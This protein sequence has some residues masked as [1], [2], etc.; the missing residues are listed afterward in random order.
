M[1][2]SGID[3]VVQEDPLA[4]FGGKWNGIAAVFMEG[5]GTRALETSKAEALH[6]RER[7]SI[8]ALGLSGK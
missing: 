1:T 3:D 5:G 7:N 2:S 4:D 6:E 8:G